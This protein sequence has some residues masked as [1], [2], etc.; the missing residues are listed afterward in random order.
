MDHEHVRSGQPPGVE[1]QAR[2]HF[3]ENLAGD[4]SQHL[5]CFL[6]MGFLVLATCGAAMRTVA[7]GPQNG[8]LSWWS[9]RVSRFPALLPT[10][11]EE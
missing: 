10:P 7:E 11:S 5:H 4:G 6:E 1:Q 2:V 3:G 9:M 8:E